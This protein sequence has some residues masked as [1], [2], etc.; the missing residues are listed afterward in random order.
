MKARDLARRRSV[1]LGYLILKRVSRE[2]GTGLFGWSHSPG[3]CERHSNGASLLWYWTAV[4]EKSSRLTAKTVY[5]A[6]ERGDLLANTILE[7]TCECLAIAIGNVITLLH[8][9][10][11]ALG[12]GVSLMGP[13]FWDSLLKKSETIRLRSVCGEL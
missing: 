6:A 4:M 1:I 11:L 7:E 2:I 5:T 3:G 13:L 10:R 8:P 9:E 12:G